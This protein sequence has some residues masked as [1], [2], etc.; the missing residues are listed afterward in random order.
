MRKFGLIGYPLSHSFSAKYFAEKF[1]KEGITNAR[2]DNYP[3]ENAADYAKLHEKD[4]D[5][6]GLNVTI[7]HKKTIVK[8]MDALSEDAREIGAVNTICFCRKTGKMVRVGHNTDVIGFRQ[9]LEEQ[10]DFTPE[11]ALVLGTGGASEAVVY[12]LE[13]MGVKFFR[14]SSSGKD[15]ALSY[16]DLSKDDVT[17]SKLIVNTTPL[18]MH[19][20][21]ES[22][23]DI[24]YDAV[25]DRHLLFDLVYNPAETVFMKKGMVQGAK[26]VNGYDML[27]YQAEGSWAIWNR[28]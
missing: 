15:D 4:P 12:V 21:V 19:P 14:V 1:R 26:V 20:N 16:K 11:Q 23:P 25:T 8:H 24:P 6:H 5:L 7:P 3:L 10:I 18:G 13:K 17:K 27:V 2:Y 22:F 9:S 28:E